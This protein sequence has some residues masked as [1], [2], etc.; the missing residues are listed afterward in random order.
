MYSRRNSYA[1]APGRWIT[2]DGEYEF[3]RSNAGGWS[4]RRRDSNRVIGTA[5]TLTA[6]FALAARHYITPVGQWNIGPAGRSADCQWSRH[7]LCLA[8]G[9]CA[10]ACHTY[11]QPVCPACTLCD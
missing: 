10:C 2:G 1:E 6:A 9:K 3:A 5:R 7:I 8:P 4:I 11:A